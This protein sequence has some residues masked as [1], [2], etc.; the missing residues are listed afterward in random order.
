MNNSEL[1]RVQAYLLRHRHAETKSMRRSISREERE[2]ATLL[3]DADLSMRSLLEEI[4]DGQGLTL[5]SFNEFDAAGIHVGAMVFVLARKPDSNPPFFGTEKLIAKMLQV[6]G[7]INKESEA[8]IWFT[9]LWF[10][11]LD[12]LYTRKNRSP[13]SLQDW[14]ET[15]FVKDVFVDAV[16]EYIN[17]HVLKIDRSTLTTDAVYETL[18]SLK[19]GTISKLCQIFIDLMCDAGLLD[20]M[21]TSNYRQSLL[22]AYEMKTNYDRQLEPL[23]P[24]A[25]PFLS[26]STLLVEQTENKTEES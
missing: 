19:E 21:E 3:R 2:V 16:K 1:G 8:K 25:D 10:I 20:E 23:L 22:F 4:L 26:A 18:T 24:K 7:G 12:L 11:L 15:T 17:D 6:R 9:Q 13:T 5:K 14:V